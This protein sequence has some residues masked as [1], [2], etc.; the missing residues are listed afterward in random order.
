M[1]SENGQDLAPIDQSSPYQLIPAEE[2]LNAEPAP[3]DIMAD[4]WTPNGSGETKKVIFQKVAPWK[5]VDPTTAEV[6]ELDCVFFT[7]FV[8]GQL[9]MIRNGSKRLVG[10]FQGNGIP[11]GTGWEVTYLGKKRNRTNSFS[12]DDWRLRPL[13]YNVTRKDIKETLHDI[14][15]RTAPE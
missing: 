13:A 12:S 10:A 11:P 7:T 15:T 2:L 14:D 8:D 6:M 9:R 5:V 3:V 4:Y 1:S